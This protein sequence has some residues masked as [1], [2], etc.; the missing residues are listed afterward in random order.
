MTKDQIIKQTN[1]ILAEHFEIDAAMIEPDEIIRQTLDL[2]SLRA[3]ELIVLAKKQFGIVIPPRQLPSL[4]T[5]EDLYDY[6]YIH[7]N[8]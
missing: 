3:M 7:V 1:A 2:D 6:L 5:F 4:V 8:T